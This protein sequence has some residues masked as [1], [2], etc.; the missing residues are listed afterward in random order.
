VFTI[1]FTRSECVLPSF[2]SE[3]LKALVCSLV[4]AVF[5]PSAATPFPS[6]STWNLKTTLVSSE[7][8]V[9]STLVSSGK[10]VQLH[11]LRVYKPQV[12]EKDNGP[13]SRGST[14]PLNV[15]ANTV[16]K[17][18]NLKTT[19]VSSEIFKKTKQTRLE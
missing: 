16:L 18:Q 12:F 14:C 13:I 1:F 3:S 5:D 19:L 8:P 17:E 2:D 11:S 4:A 9:Q 7:E 6:S 15:S 10:L